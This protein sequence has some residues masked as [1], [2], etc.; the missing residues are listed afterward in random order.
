M[1]TASRS[2]EIDVPP[3]AFLR[4]V[5]DYARYPEFL[6]EVKAVRLGPRSGGE[7]EVTYWLDVKLKMYEFTLRHVDQSPKRI[8][9]QLVRGGEFMRKNQGAWTLERTKSGGTRATYAIEI[10]FGPLVPRTFEKALAERALPNLLS[11]FKARAEKLH[12]VVR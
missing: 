2:I 1:A 11:N 6:P 10:E 9:W 5:Q 3:E 7:V 4:L 12:G 8:D